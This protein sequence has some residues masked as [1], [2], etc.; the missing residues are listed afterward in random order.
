MVQLRDGREVPAAYL[1]IISV[2]LDFPMSGS[3]YRYVHEQDNGESISGTKYE[4]GAESW[5]VWL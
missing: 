2:P 1:Y 3:T 4:L 5:W